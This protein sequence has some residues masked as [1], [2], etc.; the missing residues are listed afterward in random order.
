MAFRL[1]LFYAALF[2]V[3]GVM[4]PF[5]PVWLTSRGLGP[6]EI[7]LILSASAW[8]RA[9][10][11]PLLA[12][13]A[14]LR[15]RPDQMLVALGWAALLCH[16]LFFA[17]GGFWALLAVS[18]L[19][20]MAFS[21]LMPLGDAVTML[22][23]RRGEIDYGRV[24]LWGSLS[25]ILAA[26]GGGWLLE[27]RPED[28]ILWMMI[29]ALAAT[30]VGCHLI[31]RTETPGSAR[32]SAPLRAVLGNRRL[33]VFMAAASLLQASHAVYYGFATL[34]WRAAG[35]DD[36][37]IGA[38]WA[39]GVIAEV[40]LFTISGRLVAKTGPVPFLAIACIAGV[41]RWAVLGQTTELPALIA[42]QFLHAFTFGAAH[43]GTMHFIAREVPD[44][45]GA[46]AQSIYSS[47]AM[48]SVMAI[49]MLTA[50]WLFERYGG[51]AFY[52]MIALS[53][54]GGLM[55]L[56]AGRIGRKPS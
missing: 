20:S 51:A 54:A 3:V 26:T 16:F 25:F 47:V 18:I 6:A 53:L 31:P 36:V 8:V 35:L 19:A 55:L 21:A 32:F 15:G 14:D 4:L 45:F 5:W 7:G 56:V 30:V 27:G 9:F 50:G 42:V 33:I 11:N 12:Q 23:V 43:I 13:F 38:L 28:A 24:R 34:H 40:L 22:R 39:E 41:I 46:T 17:V 29:G 2:L 49:A 37:V 44:R 1:S 48:G 10:S 52:A